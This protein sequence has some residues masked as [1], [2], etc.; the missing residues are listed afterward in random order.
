MSDIY[1]LCTCG[2][3]K[4]FRFCCQSISTTLEKAYSQ[5]RAGQLDSAVRTFDSAIAAQ[6]D[7][8]EIYLHKARL[9]DAL[10]RRPEAEK[11]LDLALA[12]NANYASAHFLRA[13]WRMQEGE[14]PGAAILG[15]MAVDAYPADSKEQIALVYSFLADV[16]SQM[17][18]PI[19]AR[20]ALRMATRLDPANANYSSGFEELFGAK[21]D[22]PMFIR[23]EY[24][25]LSPPSGSK[26]RASWDK[27]AKE[28]RS[29]RLSD[30][31]RM[32]TTL[33]TQDSQDPAAVHNAGLINAWLGDNTQALEYLGKYIQLETDPV[34]KENALVLSEVLSTGHGSEPG[35]HAQ[36]EFVFLA[37]N[38]AAL[39]KL[40]N[41]FN[42]EKRFSPYH[43]DE[44]EQGQTIIE[45]YF[46][47]MKD[48][49]HGIITPGETAPE[50]KFARVIAHFNL[51]MPR[52]HVSGTD[53]SIIQGLRDE[54]AQGLGWTDKEAPVR[55][56][57]RLGHLAREPLMVS[58]QQG[59][60]HEELMARQ[61]AECTKEYELS[62]PH[63]KL[64]S[65]HGSTPQEAVATPEGKQRVSALIR[66]HEEASLVGQRIGYSF[67]RVRRLLGLP[68]TGTE[69]Q[70][71]VIP[72]AAVMEQSPQAA[73]QL[74][75]QA[76]DDAA[77]SSHAKAWLS[78][79]GIEDRFAAANHLARQAQ[80]AGDWAGA[81]TALESGQATDGGGRKADYLA[82]RGQCLLK[83]NRLPEACGLFDQLAAG[84]TPESRQA[85]AQAVESLVSAGHGTD[86][87]RLANTGKAQAAKA[88]NRDL[89]EHFN[90]L[91]RAAGKI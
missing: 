2:S 43:V 12:T 14:V 69:P 24:T 77:A 4:K 72:P 89:E 87:G 67:N 63:K 5:A 53:K 10:K 35:D 19:A 37:R 44:T 29:G 83:L 75:V 21:S 46:L 40:L 91:A 23:R 57:G 48:A 34:R 56:T 74:A 60:P 11:A 58:T 31:A 52:V 17:G 66:F 20:N 26:R 78:S 28:H 3:G 30:L 47:Q 49:A 8:L 70:T 22:M 81:M 68:T 15:R 36:H 42:G 54:F 86:A 7:R 62:W 82:R 25:L 85:L 79:P 27:L 45:A 55:S 61:L 51:A 76:N 18:H 16:E 64:K 13:Q 32:F 71:S 80:K 65:L 50:E 6:P 59:V 39:D 84:D 1:A 73:F 88:Q 38:P 41:K 33:A 9:L 90:E